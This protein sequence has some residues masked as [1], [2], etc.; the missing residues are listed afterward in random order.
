M[1]PTPPETRLATRPPR[2][3]P[4]SPAAA[5]AKKAEQVG[6]LFSHD[7]HSNTRRQSSRPGGQFEPCETRRQASAWSRNAAGIQP[8]HPLRIGFVA[9]AR[10]CGHATQRRLR[11]G[12]SPAAHGPGR[13]ATPARS[14]P[15]FA[16]AT[17]K[18]QSQLPS[19]TRSE[20]SELLD[21]RQR[22]RIT[23]VAQM[24]DFIG[25]AQAT[26]Q[27]GGARSC[28]SAKNGNPHSGR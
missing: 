17:R 10:G 26:G 3:P 22:R 7:R 6:N 14:R 2:R 18:F 24:P 11:A 23:H 19:T 21:S 15:E 5:E 27:S 4:A 28:V 9:R 25:A 13:T 8:A 12:F 1:T 20:R 16:R